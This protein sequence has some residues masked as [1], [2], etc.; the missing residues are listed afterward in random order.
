MQIFVYGDSFKS[1][2]I[3]IVVP[4]FAMVQ[5]A[6]KNRGKLIDINNNDELRVDQ[7]I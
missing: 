2:L 7:V 4:N 3:A 5:E 6:L 1:C